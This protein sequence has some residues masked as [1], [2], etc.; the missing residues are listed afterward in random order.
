MHVYVCALYDRNWNFWPNLLGVSNLLLMSYTKFALYADVI[1]YCLVVE[2]LSLLGSGYYF[3]TYYLRIS[4]F[5]YV[6]TPF[7]IISKSQFFQLQHVSISA[8][9]ILVPTKTWPQ[10]PTSSAVHFTLI[11]GASSKWSL[12]M[13]S[14]ILNLL[15]SGLLAVPSTLPS[16]AWLAV[17]SCSSTSAGVSHLFCIYF[18]CK[19]PSIFQLLGKHFFSFLAALSFTSSFYINVKYSNLFNI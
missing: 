8:A 5:A 10:Y 11:S 19:C 9:C 13:Q 18:I 7:F 1:F 14:S 16:P 17:P 12:F 3:L 15:C 6:T 2:D 4:F